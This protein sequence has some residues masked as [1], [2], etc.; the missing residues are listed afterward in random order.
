MTDLQN[1]ILTDE[2]RD[3]LGQLERG[4]SMFLT[5]K[6]GTGKSTLVRT[7]RTR[8]AHKTVVVAPTGIAA[9]NVSG[10]TIHRLFSFGTGINLEQ[11]KSPDYHPGRYAK[12]L[13]TMDTLIVD[14]VSMVRADLFDCVA[15][16][17]KRFGP[18]P[19]RLFGGAQ[20]IL[21]GDLFQLPPVVNERER[22]FFTTRYPSP[23]FFSADSYD[24]Q[25]FPTVEL[26]HVFRQANDQTLVDVLNS[27]RDGQLLDEK[28]A[29]LNERM[30]P[31]FEPPLDELWLTLATTN[32]IADARNRTRLEKLQTP[33]ITSTAR[34]TGDLS[35][36]DMPT[37]ETLNY[38]VGAQIMMLTNEGPW[39][40][41]TLATIVDARGV[42]GDQCVDV[43]LPDGTVAQNVKAH[44][45]DV[46]RPT[47]VG[48][49]LTSEVVG[50]FEQLPFRLAWAITIHKSQGQTLE[51]AIVDLSGGTFA[52]G[53]LY[54]ALSRIT[55]FE[56]LVLTRE[57]LPKDLRVSSAV[58]RFL[59]V[60]G[61]ARPSKGRAYLGVCTVGDT[62]ERWRPRPV[63]FAVITDDG[64]EAT[65]L[66]DPERDLADARMEFGITAEDL[67]LAPTMAQAWPALAPVLDG[68]T[69][70][71]VGIDETLANLDFELKRNGVLAPM[72]IGDEADPAV[73]AR[74]HDMLEAHSALERARA[75]RDLMSHSVKTAGTGVF[76]FN[77]HGTGFLK[78]RTASPDRF[79]VEVGPDDTHLEETLVALLADR[80]KRASAVPHAR[81]VLAA[82]DELA[83]TDTLTRAMDERRSLPIADVL[84]PGARVCFT[85]SATDCQGNVVS[86]TAIK[87]LAEAHDLIA[88][89]TVTKSRCDAL[90]SAECGSQSRKAQAAAKWA[91]PMYTVDEFYAWLS[92]NAST[93]SRGEERADVCIVPASEVGPKRGTHPAE[94]RQLPETSPKRHPVPTHDRP[95]PRRLVESS[96]QVGRGAAP[97]APAPSASMSRR[98]GV[99]PAASHPAS[100]PTV[101]TV[102]APAHGMPPVRRLRNRPNPG[103]TSSSISDPS[104]DSSQSSD[105]HRSHQPLPNHPNRH[106]HVLMAT[107]VITLA[108]V[109][110]IAGAILTGISASF[111]PAGALLILLCW[112]AAVVLIPVWIVM[113]IKK[114]RRQAVGAGKN[115]SELN[116]PVRS[117]PAHGPGRGRPSHP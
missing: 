70:A 44:G 93:P 52:D 29:I 55:T 73:A 80:A 54:V 105:A 95:R 63:E 114:S 1:L 82:I 25:S 100:P 14:E 3:A 17:L 87:A 51:R 38:K 106:F 62:G 74:A 35:D 36:F 46:R 40:N 71:G 76:T 115:A 66:I 24:A 108:V 79:C 28:R 42:D 48:G 81:A 99:D 7:F 60:S 58:R 78:P 21:V 83:G 109:G 91:K 30:M 50:S 6:A 86:R 61:P 37:E 2:F 27:V 9:L 90:V 84:V 104:V 101:P 75:T 92:G 10:L 96:S 19:G 97:S 41:G 32:R 34:K 88:V 68:Y 64:L 31:D 12:V 98:P 26:T 4:Q 15:L 20:V 11:V 39:V 113:G 43:E 47:V 116:H 13:R 103:Q 16:A 112:F 85:G 5:G 65:T 117:E 77:S 56:G 23:Y 102:S 33:I 22:E 94:P 57:V 53:Q 18:H 111:A 45:W 59:E 110:P 107:T 8:T 89:D 67:Q 72:P 69:P 49:S